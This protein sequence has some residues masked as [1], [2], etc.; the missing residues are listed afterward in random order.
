MPKLN[1]L[2]KAEEY[3][4]HSLLETRTTMLDV[5]IALIPAWMVSLWLFGYQAFAVQ[6]V[7]VAA[8]LGAEYLCRQVLK[9]PQTVS[10]LSCVV[11]GLLLSFSLPASM[12]LWQAALG[13]VMA[14]VVAKQLFGGF[15]RNFLN[16]ALFG[17]IA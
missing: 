12:P 16:P 9:K 13:S 6:M 2:F 4:P 5:L 14:I 7:C 8:A 1:W 17:R 11:T 15:G 3:I 10:D